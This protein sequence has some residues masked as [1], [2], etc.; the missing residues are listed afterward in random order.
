M[1]VIVRDN[2]AFGRVPLTRAAGGS[3]TAHFPN[4]DVADVVMRRD[5]EEHMAQTRY[6]EG[7]A[8]AQGRARADDGKRVRGVALDR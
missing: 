2:A 3:Y 5:V 6:A 4:H 8:R 7:T 1:P